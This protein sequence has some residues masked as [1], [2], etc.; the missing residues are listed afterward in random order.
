MGECAQDI[1]VKN[2]DSRHI[3]I[4]ASA[5]RLLMNAVILAILVMLMLSLLRV[6]VVASL[7]IASLLGGLY[8]GM[9]L[10]GTLAAFEAG[11][12]RGASVALSYALL[13]AF[14]VAIAKSGLPQALADV[15]VK[16]LSGDRGQQKLKY[17]ILFIVTAVAI[18][19]Q[20]LIPIH[21]A[22]IPL[23]IPPLLYVMAK[24]RLDR[25]A[26]ACAMTFGLITPYMFFPMGFGEIFLKKILLGTISN[27][28]MN[29]EG[30]SVM[31]AMGIPAAG[32]LCGLIAALFVSYRKPRDYDLEKISSNRD[33]KT[34]VSSRSVITAALAVAGAFSAQLYAHARG[35]DSGMIVGALVG[36]MIFVLSGTIKW[37]EADG[38][39]SDGIRMM[40][41]VGF[42]MITAQGF[43]EVLIRSGQIEGLVRHSAEIFAGS[44]GAAAFV[45][46]V[47]GLIITM[48]IGSSFSTIPVIAAIY[49]P[50]CMDMGFSPL[51]TVAIVGTSG[52][53]GDAGS[54]ASDSTLGP[55]SG[56]GVDGQHD[57]IWDTVVPTFLHYNLPLLAAGWIA[58]MIL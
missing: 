43:A 45:M 24:I 48:G 11:I 3:E 5:Y 33:S 56:L 54:P 47:V 40:A 22:F 29:V 53:L 50:L 14:A 52:A 23:L 49:V 2:F 41:L 34:Q 31:R 32:M 1:V 39:F 30:V 10:K 16:R 27:S 28:G 17:L 25:R 6:H 15:A 38:L 26:L 51:A 44:K 37:R 19:S 12:T 9:G 46:L 35:I 21:I 57:H 20:N 42:I 58:A 36:F 18:C 55:T 7:L 4:G 13:G 8:A